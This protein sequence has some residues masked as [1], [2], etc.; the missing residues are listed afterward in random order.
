M[1]LRSGVTDNSKEILVEICVSAGLGLDEGVNARGE[2]EEYP[3]A[4]RSKEA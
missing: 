4:R 3:S 2:E 1:G